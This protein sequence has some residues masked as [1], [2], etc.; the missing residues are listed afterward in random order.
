[1]LFLPR[2]NIS[3]RTL[4]FAFLLM[5]TWSF[6]TPVC[7]DHLVVLVRHAE[8]QTGQDPVLNEAG[9]QRAEAL[10]L[11]LR[12]LDL[13]AVFTTQL[14][15]T[16]LTG[17]PTAKAAKLEIT[18]V[19][20]NDDLDA[21]LAETAAAVRAMPDGSTVLVVGHS[22]TVPGIIGALG[23]PALEDLGKKEY[24]QLFVLHVK[25]SGKAQLI[26]STYGAK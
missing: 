6:V 7:A 3:M 4:I 20:A 24:N 17:E 25:T 10:A 16:R 21:H 8:K 18:V 26:V 15:R 13:D 12:H 9:T 1:M 19:A 2:S 23:G 22:N 14:K 11:A 5:A